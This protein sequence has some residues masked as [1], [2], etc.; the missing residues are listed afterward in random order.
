MI[1]PL[2]ILGILIKGIIEPIS[3]IILKQKTSQEAPNCSGMEH[4]ILSDSALST[5]D[6]MHHVNIFLLEVSRMRYQQA[7]SKQHASSFPFS[8]NKFS[9]HF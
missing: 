7:A 4:M 5:L 6:T 2:Y 8:F 1:D 3:Y 9:Y